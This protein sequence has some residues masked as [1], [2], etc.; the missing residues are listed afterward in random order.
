MR[1]ETALGFLVVAAA[2]VVAL[3]LKKDSDESFEDATVTSA[4][5]SL[6]TGPFEPPV[7]TP[8]S[9][10]NVPHQTYRDQVR[11]D[12][13]TAVGKTAAN[14]RRSVSASDIM[15]VVTTQRDLAVL[16]APEPL[17]DGTGSMTFTVMDLYTS[18]SMDVVATVHKGEV[19]DID[20]V[21]S[22]EST[23]VSAAGSG[24]VSEYAVQVKP[25]VRFEGNVV[26]PQFR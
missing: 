7:E 24:F 16:N 12:L 9:T 8:A 13:W 26:P 11:K 25:A 1:N 23:E 18:V 21:T 19:T 17:N 10:K 5:T 14:S 20:F 15:R 4:Q 6:P 22:G 3:K 2:A